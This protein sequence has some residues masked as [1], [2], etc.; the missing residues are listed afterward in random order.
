[1]S[2]GYESG[3]QF[4][5]RSKGSLYSELQQIQALETQAVVVK[6]GKSTPREPKCFRISDELLDMVKKRVVKGIRD[7]TKKFERKGVPR[8][9]YDFEESGEEWSKKVI[10]LFW[11][12]W[13]ETYVKP[14]EK[15]EENKIKARQ[16]QKD[17][18]DVQ[19]WWG[20][21]PVT[22]LMRL[23]T[24]QSEGWVCGLDITERMIKKKMLDCSLP[25]TP[26]FNGLALPAAIQPYFTYREESESDDED[27][28][29]ELP[30]TR[31]A[32]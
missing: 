30:L 21:A 26:M 18:D 25:R 8:K 10:E 11:V 5:A 29:Y 12:K 9:D 3:V 19:F 6:D 2:K 1:M 13:A 22:N 15:D 7:E 14:E 24:M 4:R 27:G 23:N 20:N 16:L 28:E 17:F 31:V 32:R